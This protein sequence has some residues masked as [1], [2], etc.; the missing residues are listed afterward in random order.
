MENLLLVMLLI[1]IFIIGLYTT[2]KVDLFLDKNLKITTD[3]NQNKQE[4]HDIMSGANYIGVNAHGYQP[5]A[6]H[7][8]NT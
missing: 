8:C 2:S 3:K 1:I 6:Y 4:K 5:P 7:V